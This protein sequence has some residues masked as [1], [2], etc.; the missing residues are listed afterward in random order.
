MFIYLVS[1]IFTSKPICCWPV[2]KLLRYYLW[3]LLKYTF[4]LLFTFKL[5][6]IFELIFPF[7]LS[8]DSFILLLGPVRQLQ[9]SPHVDLGAWFSRAFGIT[10]RVQIFT[11]PISNIGLSVG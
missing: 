7:Y 10:L 3:Y 1:G 2:G 9:S 5:A 4:K 8:S 6:L 11:T